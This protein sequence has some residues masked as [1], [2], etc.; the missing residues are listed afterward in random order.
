MK[1]LGFYPRL[2]FD[3]IRKN[4]RMYV[5]YLLTCVLMVCMHYILLALSAEVQLRQIRGAGSLGIILSLGAG[6]V[7]VFSL[8][9][10]FYTNAFLL[11]RRKREFGLYSVLGCGKRDL[12]R[13]ITWES[14]ISAAMALAAGLLLGVVLSLLAELGLTRLLGMGA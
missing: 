6:V 3:G 5:P 10:L 8:L 13:I 14:L 7:L 4:S 1:N 9:F 2:A 11:R 12:A